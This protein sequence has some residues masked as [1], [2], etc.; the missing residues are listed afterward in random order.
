MTRLCRRCRRPLR[1]QPWRTVGLGRRCAAI[2]G[3]RL[4]PSRPVLAP[5]G[6]VR[7]VVP[8]EDQL[9]LWD[10]VSTLGARQGGER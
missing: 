10:D 3:L 4:V 1:S 6:P 2:L 8:D 7:R 5:V 9:T